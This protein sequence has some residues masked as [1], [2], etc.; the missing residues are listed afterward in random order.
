[1]FNGTA[2]LDRAAPRF[3]P[4]KFLTLAFIYSTLE[5]C[6]EA[7]AACDRARELN[8]GFSLDEVKKLFDTLH[9]PYLEKILTALRQAGLPEE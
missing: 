7:R 9:P 8:P 2:Y 1:M 6:D 4:A 5:R 3:V